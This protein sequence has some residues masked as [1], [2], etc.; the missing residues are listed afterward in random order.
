MFMSWEWDYSS[1]QGSLPSSIYVTLT[2]WTADHDQSMTSSLMWNKKTK[3][4]NLFKPLCIEHII[5]STGGKKNVSYKE[6]IF[7]SE[8]VQTWHHKSI[9][10][11]SLLATT[12]KIQWIYFSTPEHKLCAFVVK[13]MMSPVEFYLASPRGLS[14][15][16]ATPTHNDPWPILSI[17]RWDWASLIFLPHDSKSPKLFLMAFAW[18]TFYLD[19]G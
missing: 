17:F 7:H 3:K 1:F 13:R 16:S 11:P 18:V 2:L 14:G 4:N 15:Q 5:I 6:W 10:S 12:K 19:F 8:I 9:S